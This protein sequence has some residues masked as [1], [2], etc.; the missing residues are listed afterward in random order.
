MK[1]TPYKPKYDVT[2]AKYPAWKCEL[3]PITLHLTTI[4]LYRIFSDRATQMIHIV[5]V[6]YQVLW[7]YMVV[8]NLAYPE[9]EKGGSRDFKIENNYS[10]NAINYSTL[11]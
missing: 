10:T 3:M 5:H 4:Q 11:H 7:P 8:L 6:H 9:K 2:E 1:E